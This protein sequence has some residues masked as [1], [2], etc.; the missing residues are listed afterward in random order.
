MWVGEHQCGCV[1]GGRC[2]I[3]ERVFNLSCVGGGEVGCG[4]AGVMLRR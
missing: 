1:G 4:V 3:S 2:V